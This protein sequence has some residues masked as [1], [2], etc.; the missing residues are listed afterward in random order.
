MDVGI[1][2]KVGTIRA[3]NIRS[4][5]FIFGKEPLGDVGIIKTPLWLI[6]SLSRMVRNSKMFPVGDWVVAVVGDL[7][8]KSTLLDKSVFFW[9]VQ[10]PQYGFGK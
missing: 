5:A 10:D 8:E 9:A 3:G 2:L 6:S 4:A 1:I 7:G